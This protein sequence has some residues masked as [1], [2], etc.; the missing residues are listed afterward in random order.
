MIAVQVVLCGLSVC[1]PSII[2]GLAPAVATAQTFNENV[3]GD[4]TTLSLAKKFDDSCD[5]LDSV[6]RAAFHRAVMQ[7]IAS[8]SEPD[9]TKARMRASWQNQRRDPQY[10]CAGNR[11][12]EVVLWR[13]RDSKGEDPRAQFKFLML[14]KNFELKCRALSNAGLQAFYEAGLSW[15]ANSGASEQQRNA[16]TADWQRKNPSE[17]ADCDKG[18]FDFMVTWTFRAKEGGQ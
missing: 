17:D 12:L 13:F 2:P 14:G 10:D 4:L 8:L 5:V 18:M 16:M 3:V 6:A 11:F 15:I 9:D 7:W 1:V